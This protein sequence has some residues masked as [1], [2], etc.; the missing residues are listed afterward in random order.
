MPAGRQAHGEAPRPVEDR[1]DEPVLAAE[2]G[3]GDLR[4][5]DLCSMSIEGLRDAGRLAEPDDEAS[6][7]QMTARTTSSAPTVE[8]LPC[9]TSIFTTLRIQKMPTTMSTSA[10]DAS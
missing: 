7:T 10:A 6:T 2:L 3:L 8:E 1:R 4:V 5:V 9:Q